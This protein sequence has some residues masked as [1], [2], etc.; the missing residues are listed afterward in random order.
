MLERLWQLYQHDLSEFRG[1]HAPTGLR[2]TLPGVEGTFASGRLDAY[3][4]DD[5]DRAVYV[6]QLDG[7]PV[8]FAFVRGVAS[9]PCLMGEFFVARGARRSGVG[10]AA[11]EQLLALHPGVWEIPFQE[12]NAAGARF[13]RSVIAGLALDSVREEHRAVP[14]KPEVPPDVWLTV[15]C[16]SKGP[17]GPDA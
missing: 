14:G 13:W 4:A 9:G 16:G 2:R 7:R 17:V 6:F 12:A 5:R 1:E 10:R 8:G 15:L 3:L 11:V